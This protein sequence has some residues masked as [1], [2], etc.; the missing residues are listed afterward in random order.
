M[1][2]EKI[3][4]ILFFIIGLLMSFLALYLINYYKSENKNKSAT[5][6]EVSIKEKDSTNFNDSKNSKSTGSSLNI[7]ELT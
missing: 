4:L 2:K 7:S 6:S 1:N 5:P 3:K